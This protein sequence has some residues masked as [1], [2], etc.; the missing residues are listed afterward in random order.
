M[1]KTSKILSVVLAILM[2]ITIIPIS[3]CA[4]EIAVNYDYTVISEEEKTCRLNS[5]DGI[6]RTDSVI[7][8]IPS[9]VDGYM[10]IELS[11]NFNYNSNTDKVVVP[12]SVERIGRAFNGKNG[13]FTIVLGSGVSDFEAKNF[14]NMNCLEEFIVSEDNPYICSVDGVVF[15]KDMKTLLRFPTDSKNGI[16]YEIPDGV[17]IIGKDAFNQGW[18]L[19]TIKIPDSVITIEEHAFSGCEKVER[20]D[21]GKGIT[22]IGYYAF[23]NC[24]KLANVYYAS[25]EEDWAKISINSKGNNNLVNAQIHFDENA[26]HT[27]NLEFVETVAPTCGEDGYTLYYCDGCEEYFEKDYV[28]A[29]GIHDY[30]QSVIT[31]P[32]CTAQGFTTYSCE[33]GEYYID[34]YVDAL[35]HNYEEK[36]TPPDETECV[37]VY[38]CSS[39][40]DSYTVNGHTKVVVPAKVPTI[41]EAGNT[42][43][44]RCSNCGKIFVEGQTIPALNEDSFATLQGDNLIGV[45]DKEAR[46]LTIYGTGTI[47]AEH[48]FTSVYDK[49]WGMNIGYLSFVD[50]VIITEGITGIGDDAFSGYPIDSVIIPDS[51]T[52][53]GD[54][55]FYES[56]IA[57]V[58][59]GD[60]VETIGSNAFGGCY[61]LTTVYY[62]G[63]EEQW[64]EIVIESNNQDLFDATI[65]FNG[66]RPHTH[67]YESIIT[68]PTC[69]GRGYTTYTCICGDSYVSDYVDAL[70]HNHTSEITTPATHTATG[71]MTYT[72]TCGDTYT[73]VIDK[74]ANH[75]Y[76]TVITAPT[77]TEQ[78]FTTYTC[79]CGDSYVGDY[80]DE[81]GHTEEIIQAV[82]PTCTETGLTEGVK[83]SVCGEIITAQQEIPANGHT[84]EIIPAVA[85]TCT[86]TGLT[87]GTK[88]SVCCE[89]LTVQQEI[90]ATGHSSANA[91]EENYVASTCTSNGSVDKVVYCSVCDEE[92]SRETE[93]IQMLGHA[94]NDGDGACDMCDETLDPTVECDCNCHKSGISNFF[95]KFALFFQK[96]FSLNKYCECGV[97][98]Y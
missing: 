47:E 33:C 17:E 38:K 28:E 44:E 66:T 42:C 20:I 93:T 41:T 39:C 11:D 86:E 71:V 98:H 65:Y 8:V 53:I 54:S 32:T 59:M 70:G 13:L 88:C 55:A 51:V 87:E 82:T 56:E 22:T 60:G 15:S 10:V 79:I 2:V 69:T 30:N 1:K 36:E 21:M 34:N 80:V 61:Y 63:T 81:L 45:L 96:L 50:T 67:E 84:E 4:E 37:K 31:T 78:G 14:V 76:D 9:E 29:T 48:D 83:C 19:K 49:D 97:T 90:S 73:E 57:T 18:N 43:D 64:A 95:F 25:T 26:G 12:N 16:I 52:T 7:L 92:L 6:S 35:G 3:A 89:I 62:S 74:L 75:K 94:D 27:H 68:A 40:D 77:C 46:T 91:V 24:V 23:G 85:P 72:C 5:D 58:T